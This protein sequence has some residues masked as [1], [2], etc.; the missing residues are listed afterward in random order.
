MH[1]NTKITCRRSSRLSAIESQSE[2]SHPE[3]T[4]PVVSRRRRLQSSPMSE[5]RP[6]KRSKR[7][8]STKETNTG[9][10]SLKREASSFSVP[11]NRKRKAE[12]SYQPADFP[13]RPES[14]WRIGPHVSSAGGVENTIINAAS[15]GS[16]AT[17][18]S[19]LLLLGSPLECRATAFAL[20]VKSQRKWTSPPTKPES[21]A[22]FKSRLKDFGYST[23]HILPHGSYLVN[24]GNPDA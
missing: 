10:S 20:F 3:T 1:S 17:Y 6:T 16:V 4:A 2:L 19:I 24:M 14:E 13:S 11:K 22:S 9:D 15:I 21:I 23:E 8:R 12:I 18:H 5:E 7:S